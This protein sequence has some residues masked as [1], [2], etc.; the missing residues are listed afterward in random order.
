MADAFPPTEKNSL[1]VVPQEDLLP[2]HGEHV[3]PFSDEGG[4]R[5]FYGQSYDPGSGLW[6]DQGAGLW[7]E[8]G[9]PDWFG[10]HVGPGFASASSAARRDVSHRPGWSVSPSGAG[11]GHFNGVELA[12]AGAVVVLGVR[13]EEE[14]ADG[15][16]LQG[17]GRD[18]LEKMERGGPIRQMLENLGRELAGGGPSVAGVSIPDATK[19]P[20][21]PDSL[22]R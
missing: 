12:G 21:G 10:D 11:G 16:E 14:E 9:R 1:Q 18:I 7:S 22:S 8:P 6:Y 2:D 5:L 20:R 3:G 17:G 15:A 4:P 13:L 19:T